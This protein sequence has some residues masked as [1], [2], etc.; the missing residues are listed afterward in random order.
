MSDS[1]T[2]FFPQCAESIMQLDIGK[3]KQSCLVMGETAVAVVSPL[4][5]IGDTS[6]S[7]Q[8]GLKYSMGKLLK[9]GSDH[10]GR[11]AVR[12]LES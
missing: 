5:A 3:K 10:T 1:S 2:T 12:F 9:R 7:P 8:N 6:N 11:K 4:A